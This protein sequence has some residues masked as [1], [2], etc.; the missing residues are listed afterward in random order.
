LS[1][2]LVLTNGRILT[3]MSG[4]V[5]ALAAVGG[6][7]VAVGDQES[8]AA[9][10]GSRTRV[11]DLG[12]R[13]ATPGLTDSHVH[14]GSLAL[15]LSK[16]DLSRA[17]SLPAALRRVA[18]R[19]RRTPAGGW[20]T[21]GGFDKNRWGHGFPTRRDL[22]GAAPDHP[23]ALSSRDGHTLWVNSLA[24]RLC[25]VTRHTKAPAGGVIMRDARG[26][27]S[28]ILQE[29]ALRLIYDA[30]AFEGRAP[31]T[32]ELLAAARFVLRHG[33][34]SAHLMEEMDLW[35]A[36]Q[37]LRQ[38]RRPSPRMTVYRRAGAVGDLVRAGVRSGLGDEWLRV[39]GVKL[40]IDGSLGSQTAWLFEAYENAPGAGRGVATL[41]GRELREVV[42]SAASGG[43][44]C[45]I[46][47]IGDRANAEALDALAAVRDLPTAL[48]HRIE[49]AQLV[50]A[51][52]ISRFAQLGV[53]ASMQPCHILG[54]I[55]PADRY[56]G[57]RSRWAYPVRSLEKAGAALAF[58]SDAPVE[59]ADPIAGIFAAVQRQTREGLPD[60][61]WYREQEAITPRSALHAYTVG[62]AMATREGSFKGRL[63]PGFL[64]DVVVWSQD[65][66]RLRGRRLLGARPDMVFVGGRLCYRR[67][68]V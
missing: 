34:T 32:A 4:S 6:R 50:R 1:A 7:V 27:P 49:H 58:G 16:L 39:G 62:P 14:L 48:P 35:R 29:R 2:D 55:E 23:V 31:G 44:A 60:G 61:G 56:W 46:H 21:G 41:R 40:L 57:R 5:A 45:A 26:E 12:G 9:L 18:A 38:S 28:G 17:Q 47:A 20:I 64:A 19:T 67:R 11:H 65:F 51:R 42:H 68:G 52:D 66:T 63:A 10:I 8:V 53:V 22:D 30:P 13:L 15:R 25:R 3:M 54:D 33:V 36:L 24:L 37:D 59:T 43:L